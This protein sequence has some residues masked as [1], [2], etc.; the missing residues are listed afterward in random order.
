MKINK[1]AD[2]YTGLNS[3]KTAE[4]ANIP[5][6]SQEETVV[7]G[8]SPGDL[9]IMDKQS[10]K[11]LTSQSGLEPFKKYKLVKVKPEKEFTLQD[12]LRFAGFLTL[13]VG[14]PVGMTVVGAAGRAIAGLP[15]AIIAT[16]AATG[17]GA[18]IGG[19][20][21]AVQTGVGAATAAVIGGYFGVSAGI[22]AELTVMTAQDRCI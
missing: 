3:P 14:V 11:N 22:M 16:A 5:A 4:K 17:V 8:D 12:N 20:E 7:L 19:K 13:R 10:M 6:K 21:I 15:G 1:N 9:G 2:L 18:L